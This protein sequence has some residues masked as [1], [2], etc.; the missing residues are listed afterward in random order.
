[1]FVEGVLIYKLLHL[2]WD[3]IWKIGMKSFHK[4]NDKEVWDVYVNDFLLL[5]EL[6]KYAST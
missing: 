4:L 5:L 1:M 3:K 2:L 6:L